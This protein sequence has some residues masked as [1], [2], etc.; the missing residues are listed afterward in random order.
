[1]KVDFLKMFL[2]FHVPPP[3]GKELMH[4]VFVGQANYLECVNDIV[5]MKGTSNA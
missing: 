2:N 5:P 4:L 3:F 1:V